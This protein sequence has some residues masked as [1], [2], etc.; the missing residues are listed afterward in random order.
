[1][2]CVPPE[3]EI[4]LAIFLKSSAGSDA[5]FNPSCD[6]VFLSHFLTDPGE[7]A[8]LGPKGEEAALAGVEVEELKESAMAQT[9]LAGSKTSCR[10]GGLV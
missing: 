9:G 6:E 3:R 5:L 7:N 4:F 1:M 2:F 8:F 10:G